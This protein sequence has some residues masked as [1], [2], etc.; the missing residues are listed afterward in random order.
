MKFTKECA[1]FS[2]RHVLVK[3]FFTIRQNRGLPLH[4]SV[5]KTSP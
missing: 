1:M 3:T 4:S 5:E 2:E